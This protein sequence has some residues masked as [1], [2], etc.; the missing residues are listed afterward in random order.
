[1]KKRVNRLLNEEQEQVSARRAPVSRCE[2]Q[3]DR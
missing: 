3:D 2:V 1:M